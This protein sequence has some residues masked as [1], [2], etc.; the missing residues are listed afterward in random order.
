MT[1]YMVWGDEG[2]TYAYQLPKF[3][4]FIADCI[5]F[6]TKSFVDRIMGEQWEQMIFF[7]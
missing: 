2:R 3:F 4:N 7:S 5:I 6:I 1:E